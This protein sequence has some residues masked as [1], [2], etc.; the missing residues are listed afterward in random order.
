[1]ALPT[2]ALSQQTAQERP[3]YWWELIDLSTEAAVDLVPYDWLKNQ[4]EKLVVLSSN[5]VAHDGSRADVP[6][7]MPPAEALSQEAGH[8][9]TLDE[10]RQRF[11]K[12]H[13]Q[14]YFL[15]GKDLEQFMYRE[16][17]SDLLQMKNVQLLGSIAPNGNWRR[18]PKPK[19]M[20]FRNFFFRCKNQWKGCTWNFYKNQMDPSGHSG[21]VKLLDYVQTIQHIIDCTKTGKTV[22]QCAKDYLL[23]FAL[24][25]SVMEFIKSSVSFASWKYMGQEAGAAIEAGSTAV[26]LANFGFLAYADYKALQEISL[27][28]E[29]REKLEKT[30]QS[31]RQ[32]EERNLEIDKA[33]W[34]G[35]ASSL[36]AIFDL[37]WQQYN[38]RAIKLEKELLYTWAYATDT[39]KELQKR[40]EILASEL[41]K[42]KKDCKNDQRALN[43]LLNGDKRF[44]PI[45]STLNF[46]LNTAYS[47]FKQEYFSSNICANDQLRS[48]AFENYGKIKQLLAKIDQQLTTI[49]KNWQQFEQKEKDKIIGLANQFVKPVVLAPGLY[50]AYLDFLLA[51]GQNMA[52]VNR[53]L[54]LNRAYYRTNTRYTHG[55]LRNLLLFLNSR[56]DTFPNEETQEKFRE[57]LQEF[58]QKIQERKPHYC[59]L[60]PKY[61]LKAPCS[62][63]DSLIKGYNMEI[64]SMTRDL[65]YADGTG[66]QLRT[67]IESELSRF[68]DIVRIN[69]KNASPEL[70]QNLVLGLKKAYHDANLLEINLRA[71]ES[72]KEPQAMWVLVRPPEI[73]NSPSGQRKYCSGIDSYEHYLS[74]GQYQS[75][76]YENHRSCPGNAD[77]SAIIKFQSPPQKIEAGAAFRLQAMGTI[78]GFQDSNGYRGE[79]FV[80]DTRGCPGATITPSK[81]EQAKVYVDLRGLSKKPMLLNYP[82]ARTGWAGEHSDSLNIVWKMPENPR[83]GDK[84]TILGRTPNGHIK[85]HYV[86]KVIN[87]Q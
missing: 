33:L 48:E 27:F 45:L 80:Y 31:N 71:C 43:M 63:S 75:R 21:K 77:L 5:A 22:R 64:E 29:E 10:I 84:C 52:M 62:S 58:E 49:Q 74:I 44:K 12:N 78:R 67:T 51:Y 46:D 1:M 66:L 26:S 23:P 79:W 68:K 11:R 24:S 8:D 7:D 82:L 69:S 6:G 60:S 59:G 20:T 57:K 16:R 28:L 47:L 40:Q 18:I 35:S 19:P 9:L 17:L 70:F 73:K 86:F 30:K 32:L 14:Y 55:R 25:K 37:F 53:L 56:I 81:G 41:K 38:S 85:W 87:Q 3:P 83:P 36:K 15:R 61:N 39:A 34:D 4:A 42:F 13:P 65:Y 54:K 2:F 72:S 50:E 76:Q